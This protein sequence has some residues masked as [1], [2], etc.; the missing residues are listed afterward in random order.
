MNTM[1]AG[2]FDPRLEDLA[3]HVREEVG[4]EPLSPVDPWVLADHLD[5]QVQVALELASQTRRP[6]EP[7]DLEGLVD[8][9]VLPLTMFR[10]AQRMILVGSARGS[11][12]CR[13]EVTHE[14]AH[15][16][17]E[18]PLASCDGRDGV[19]IWTP[20]QEAEADWLAAAILVPAIPE[21]NLASDREI[22]TAYG[23]DRRVVRLRRPTGC[24]R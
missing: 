19:A 18:H 12:R 2:P 23:V 16:V 6:V 13:Y 3:R 21:G 10:G 22:A 9:G 1:T 20:R 17:L 15:A 4:A 7:A 5:V 24:P 8:Q 11:R 14:L